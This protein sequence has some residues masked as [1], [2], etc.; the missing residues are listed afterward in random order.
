[1]FVFAFDNVWGWSGVV[2]AMLFSFCV[3]GKKGI[4]EDR[5]DS[6]GLWQLEMGIGVVTRENFKGSMVVGCKF[7]FR[8]GRLDISSFKPY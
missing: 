3:R 8:V 7:G 1:M 6:P 2:G 5:V 4:V